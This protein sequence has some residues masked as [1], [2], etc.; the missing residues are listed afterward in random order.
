MSHLSLVHSGV[1]LVNSHTV[2]VNAGKCHAG[3]LREIRMTLL[4][5]PAAR[6]C[7]SPGSYLDR[8][9]KPRP[10]YDMTNEGL[11]ML[12]LGWNELRWI[13]FRANY[14]KAMFAKTYPDRVRLVRLIERELT[15]LRRAGDVQRPRLVITDGMPNASMRTRDLPSL[16]AP[17]R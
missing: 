2:A 8:Q 12:V 10:A 6:V 16:I 13:R 11:M 5:C 1:A 9:H 3:L 17:S 14:F 7:F 15:D 4:T